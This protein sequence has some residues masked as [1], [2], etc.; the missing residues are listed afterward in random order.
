[1]D[2]AIRVA[3]VV[4]KVVLGGV[5]TMVM[6]YY[7][8]IDRTKIQFDFFM[9]GVEKTPIDDEIFDMGGKVYK[10]PAYTDSMRAN[11]D[12]FRTILDQTS[13]QIVH[14]HLNS[15]NVFWLRA[16]KQAGVPVRIS[17]SHNT[18]AWGEHMRN[19]MKY[20]LRPFSRLYP[21]HF[22]ACS[23]HAARWLFGS[24]LFDS[25]KVQLV[26]NAI[27]LTNFLFSAESRNAI[28]QS[29]GIQDRFVVGHVGR[30]V[31]QKN[32]H[33]LLKVFRNIYDKCPDA[34]LLLVGD[35]PLKEEIQQTARDMGLGHAVIFT[36]NR[37]D[38]PALLN[39]M[40]CFLFPSHYEGLGIALVEAQCSGLPCFASNG[41]PEEASLTP[42]C[43]RLDINMPAQKWAELILNFP[44]HSRDSWLGALQMA[45]YDI[46]CE[47]EKLERYYLEKL[48]SVL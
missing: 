9:D 14:S 31:Y 2:K 18:A 24:K 6:N 33:F 11:I 42:L 34:V 26:K 46:T 38:I 39:G 43:H 36:G 17:H 37:Q 19:I 20:T 3:Q 10:L 15:L 35:G 45:G 12:A 16:A 5:D 23:A 13:Y 47:A 40:D 7:R 44:S 29:L 25:G 48:P 21:T 22:C 8:H 41:T 1:M 4:G 30:F 27:P 32:H 28:R